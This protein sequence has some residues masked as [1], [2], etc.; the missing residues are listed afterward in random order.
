MVRHDSILRSKTMARNLE[1]SIRIEMNET[2]SP[3]SGNA[4]EVEAISPG[5]F[6]LVLDGAKSLDIDALENG[7]LRTSY[8]AIR[9]ALATHLADEVKKMPNQNASFS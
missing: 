3:L 4:D 6:R 7:L 8:P 5:Q 9:N 2:D 1:V